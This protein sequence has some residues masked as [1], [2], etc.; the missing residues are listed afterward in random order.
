MVIGSHRIRN[1]ATWTAGFPVFVCGALFRR[2]VVYA[3]AYIKMW[4]GRFDS[5]I[6]M[7]TA[8]IFSAGLN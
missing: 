3:A 5:M 7:L 2:T 4:V 8:S 1:V 6:I